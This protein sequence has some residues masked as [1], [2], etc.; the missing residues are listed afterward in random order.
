MSPPTKLPAAAPQATGTRPGEPSIP[1]PA[2]IRGT[3]RARHLW[4][5]AAGAV[6]SRWDVLAVIAAGGALGSLARWGVSLAIPA[7]PG[8]F[9]WASFVINV[10]GC[11]LLGALIV[12]AGEVWPPS[13]YAR[14]FLGV[15]LLGGYTTFSAFMLDTRGLLVTGHPAAAG[16]YL[17]GS[18]TAGLIAVWA[19]AAAV[20]SA[21]RLA[22]WH[23]R[24]EADR[25]YQ[26][27]GSRGSAA[28]TPAPRSPR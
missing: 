13:R 4:T 19:G 15:G 14:T 6:R 26:S 23:A 21:I 20:R 17:L 7:Q 27:G 10:S 5:Q 1:V 9:P 12:L 8:A 2:R 18:I 28:P 24:R 22:R 3:T 11:L 25:R 16:A